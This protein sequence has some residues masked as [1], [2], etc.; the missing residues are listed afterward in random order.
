MPTNIDAVP[1]STYITDERETKRDLW[2]GLLAS[3][4]LY[5]LY[6]IAGYLL[7]EAA[8]TEMFD[9]TNQQLTTSIGWLTI[10]AAGMTL[11]TALYGY[12]NWRR[13]RQRD[14][15]TGGALAF[16]AFGGLLLGILFT[17]LVAVTGTTTFFVE[18]CVWL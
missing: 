15:A 1:K 18:P 8:C 3:P 7:S 13:N 14:D 11:A 6:F 17:L 9:L 2:L 16:M 4:I 5:A 12:Q 10:L